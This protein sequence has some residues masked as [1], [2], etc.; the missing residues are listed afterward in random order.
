VLQAAGAAAQIQLW[1]PL[2]PAGLF[3]YSIRSP[4]LPPIMSVNSAGY[5]LLCLLA[6]I[7]EAAGF[8]LD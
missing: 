6:P 2:F 8:R 5:Q 3:F 4:P 1:F 7:E